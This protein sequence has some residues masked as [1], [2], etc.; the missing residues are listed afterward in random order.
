MMSRVATGHV[1]AGALLLLAQYGG[2]TF[3]NRGVDQIE[4][5]MTRPVP[6]APVAPGGTIS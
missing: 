2:G 4:R 6:Q 3:F 1:P 5:S